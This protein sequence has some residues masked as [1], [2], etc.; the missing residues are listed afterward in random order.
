MGAPGAPDKTLKKTGWSGGGVTN[1]T[2]II[3]S[4]SWLRLCPLAVAF[5]S[6]GPFQ[7]LTNPPML[8]GWADSH[9]L[10]R[11][12]PASPALPSLC[13][14]RQSLSVLLSSSSAV[15]HQSL[16]ISS[17]KTGVV[18]FLLCTPHLVHCP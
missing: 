7:N 2:L 14:E 10:Q 13:T 5:L 3:S 6:S 12:L 16:C 1:H 15:V 8:S 18:A 11:A 9:L 4:R 17:L